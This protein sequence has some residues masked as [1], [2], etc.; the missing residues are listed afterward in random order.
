MAIKLLTVRGQKNP[1]EPAYLVSA[2]LL[3][4]F[5]FMPPFIDVDVW[6]P[7]RDGF[8][9]VFVFCGNPVSPQESLALESDAGTVAGESAARRI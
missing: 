6:M 2:C 7:A 5:P 9:P 3:P 8:L 4:C 1:T